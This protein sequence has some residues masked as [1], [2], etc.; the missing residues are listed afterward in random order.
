MKQELKARSSLYLIGAFFIFARLIMVIFG[1]NSSTVTTTANW[2]FVIRD[3]GI[4]RKQRGEP[5]GR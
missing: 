1:H 5:L 4:I 2:N 3:D